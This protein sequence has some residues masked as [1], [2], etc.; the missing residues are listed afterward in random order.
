MPSATTPLGV[1]V[2]D[3]RA[4][5]GLTAKSLDC[6][7]TGDVICSYVL[8]VAPT[9]QV[10][11]PKRFNLRCCGDT[12]VSFGH[13][14]DLLMLDILYLFIISDANDAASSTAMIE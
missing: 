13:V 1:L 9:K 7:G 10:T 14:V 3:G 2:D 12:L 6:V 8:H 5:D 4:D 11:S